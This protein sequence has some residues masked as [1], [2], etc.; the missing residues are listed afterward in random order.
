MKFKKLSPAAE[1]NLILISSLFYW[2]ALYIY[3]PILSPYAKELGGSLTI[4]GLV[5]SSY[6]LAQLLFRLPIG[7]W[8]DISGKRKPFVISGFLFAFVGCIGLALSP[9]PWIMLIFRAISGVSASM[10]VV[11]TV[12][13]SSYFHDAQSARSMSLITFC[14]GFAQMIST[15]AGG[16][17]AEKYGWL[18]PFYWG[19]GL[20]LIGALVL[21]PVSDNKL[22]NRSGFS[23]QRLLS[24]ASRKRLLIVSIITALNQFAVFITV[25]GFLPVY[26]TNIGA[27]KSQLGAL[28][29]IVHLTQTLSMYLAG[30]YVV[31]RLGYK[32]TVSFSHICIALATFITPYIQKIHPLIAIS[33]IGALGQGFAYP[34][35]M[36]LA[37]QGVPAEDKATAMGFY[38]AVYAIGMFLGPAIGG[39]IGDAFGL[40]GV[41]FCA[42]IVYV[43]AS[44]VSAF[45]LPG[46]KS[47][48][49]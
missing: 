9:N 10:W 32:I 49:S 23:V 8:S 39:F 22:E 5:I 21:L 45:T 2:S 15:Y 46:L 44:V 20:S 29:F 42:G 16:N 43:V 14:T 18:M 13:Y 1:K 28:M 7:I 27:S 33:G 6:G 30:T 38:Q 41:F 25:Y 26:A 34:L 36:G 11:Y 24:V 12:M 3:V 40:K 4:I 17:L 31:P 48:N 47:K 19:A 37:I 35:L